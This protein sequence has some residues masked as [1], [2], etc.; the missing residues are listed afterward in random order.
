MTLIG[1][2]WRPQQDSGKNKKVWGLIPAGL[3]DAV[4]QEFREDTPLMTACF[5]QADQH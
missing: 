3:W 2:S 1:F 5:I 4:G